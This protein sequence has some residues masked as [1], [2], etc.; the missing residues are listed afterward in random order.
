IYADPRCTEMARYATEWLQLRP[1]TDGAIFLSWIN[2]IIK[3]GIFDRDFVVNWSNA[4]FLVRTDSRKILRE[5]DVKKGGS[6]EN[7]VV[8]NEK[9]NDTSVWISDRREF[10][11]PDVEP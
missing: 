9:T 4:P 2:R 5:A 8:W 1:A 6:R 10:D 11:S 7:F 3:D